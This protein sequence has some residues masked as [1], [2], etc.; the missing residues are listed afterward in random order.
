M[1]L[2]EYLGFDKT[3]K[4]VKGTIDADG[5]RAAQRKLVGMGIYAKEV[6]DGELKKANDID[7]SKYFGTSKISAKE[8]SIITRQLATL[9]GARLPLVKALNAL[10][11]QVDSKSTKSILTEIREDVEQGST[12]AK[13]LNKHSSFSRLYVNMVSAGEAS[14]T[15]HTVLNQLADYLEDQMNL[16]RKVRSATTY[17]VIMLIICSLIVLALFVFVIPSVI[18][19]FKKQGAILPLPTRIVLFISDMI[20]GYWY[21]ML[22]FLISIPIVYRWYYK[23]ENGKKNIDWILMKIPIAG[24][25]YV[26]VACARI[27]Q[28]LAALLSAGVGLLPA[29][30]ITTKIFGNK[31]IVES[32]E[33]ARDGVREGRPLSKELTKSGIYPSMLPQMIAIGEESGE[34]EEM[35]NKA[36]SV[37]KSEVDS[38]LDGLTATLEPLLM[39]VVGT[40]VLLIVI[41]VLLPF[42]DLIDLI[43]KKPS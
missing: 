19:M 9:V 7:L 10:A 32:L 18:E 11:D 13:A 37:Y 3:G 25:V 38:S 30:E 33:N 21:L 24:S 42:F 43:G 28:T 16:R 26:K 36:G 27:S 39:V 40:V 41:A 22:A 2:F 31:H 34:L 35:L 20:I 17:P 8:M 14:G 29:L 1:P 6:K 12:F 23:T 5:L 15:L 4:Q